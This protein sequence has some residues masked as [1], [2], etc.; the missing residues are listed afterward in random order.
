MNFTPV[1]DVNDHVAHI[2]HIATRF[3]ERSQ[4]LSK[5]V[6]GG[7]D[8]PELFAFVVEEEFTAMLDVEIEPHDLLLKSPQR[9][10]EKASSC[11]F[12]LCRWGLDF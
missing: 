1:C 7:T 10:C 3:K 6:A 2:G 9:C 12:G 5:V 4:Y 8:G 11:W